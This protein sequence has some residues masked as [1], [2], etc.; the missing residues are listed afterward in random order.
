M[1]MHVHVRVYLLSYLHVCMHVHVV[2][3]VHVYCVLVHVCT[4]AVIIGVSQ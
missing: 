2:L 4:Y 1:Y 3:K